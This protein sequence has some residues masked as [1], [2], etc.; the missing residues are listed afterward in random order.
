M[1]SIRINYID[2]IAVNSAYFEA[3]WTDC[4]ALTVMT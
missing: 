1:L 2:V 4:E 3:R